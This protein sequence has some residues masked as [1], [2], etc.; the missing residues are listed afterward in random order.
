MIDPHV[1]LR[2]WEQSHKETLYHGLRSA[3]SAG[4]SLVLDMPNT[5]P[6]LTGEAMIRKR[7]EDADAAAAA[8]MHD[9]GLRI[10]Y[11][12]YGGLTADLEQVKE[13]V[14]LHA[15]IFPRLVGLKLFAGHSTGRMGIPSVADRAGLFSLLAGQHYRGV[16][17]V[18][19][20]KEELLRPELWDDSDPFSH[21]RAR[22]ATAEIVSVE[23]QIRLADEAGFAG[24]LHIC[25]VSTPAALEVIEDARTHVAFR[26][27]CGATPHHLLL[28]SSFPGPGELVKVNPPLRSPEERNGLYHALLEGRIDWI[29]TDHA[30]HTPADKQQGASGIPGFHGHLLLLKRLL[31]DGVPVRQLQALTHGN[32]ADVFS[33]T[34]SGDE[35]TFFRA[36]RLEARAVLVAGRYAADPYCYIDAAEMSGIST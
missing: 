21:S 4:F 25:H 26:I 36:D 8:V 12:L 2:D 32:C 6:P 34:L 33:F 30:P 29:E 3:A 9:T 19:C 15:G 31:H 23:E 1:H 18:H 27:T 5:V 10:A 14:R 11:G 17:A 24:T 28:D 13:L 20:E 7:L 16:V 35:A 22:P